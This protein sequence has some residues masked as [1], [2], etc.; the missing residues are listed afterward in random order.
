MLSS[1]A[2][3]YL[4][5]LLDGRRHDA[6]RLVLAEVERGALT[7]EALYLDVLEPVLV[8]VGRRWQHN[9]VSIAEEHY[10]SAATQTVMA[11]L[12]PRIFASKR[13]GTVMVAACVGPELH[14][15]GLRM[16]AD[17]FEIDG[18]DTYYLGANVP[19][20]SIVRAVRERRADLVALS[21]AL[22][23]HLEIAREVIDELRADPVTAAV[24]VL[25]G[26]HALQGAPDRWRELGASAPA[27]DAADAVA[28]ARR[29]VGGRHG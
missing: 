18:W 7:I 24:P 12:Y 27:R 14:E 1:L 17:L 21:A 23:G 26:G 28:V 2:D 19:A 13:R 20:A 6:A 4:A 3:A 29:L 9:L 5:T 25:V 16:V 22:G 10:V 11:Q 8:E 15:I